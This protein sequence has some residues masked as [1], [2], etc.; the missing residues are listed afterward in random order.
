[1]A[2]DMNYAGGGPGA[3]K[4]N[5]DKLGGSGAVFTAAYGDHPICAPSRA[6]IM[7]GI[8]GGVS[9][10]YMGR[11][12]NYESALSDSYYWWDNAI[13]AN[14][15]Q[16]PEF[17]RSKCYYVAASGKVN[18]NE[19]PEA[20]CPECLWDEFY[21]EPDYGPYAFD[22]EKET[23]HDELPAA[24]AEISNAIDYGWARLSHVPYANTAKGG[25]KYAGG[26][27]K[28]GPRGMF[29]FNSVEDRAPTS[30][31]YNAE[32]AIQKIQQW[33]TTKAE[34]PWL[35]M[36][37]FVKPHTP[38]HCPDEHFDSFPLDEVVLPVGWDDDASDTFYEAASTEN[39][40]GYHLAHALKDSYDGGFEEGLRYW[41]QAYYACV[42]FVDVQVGKVVDA[43]EKSSFASN[44][45][46]VFMSDNG[47]QN[48]AKHY[49][50]K[51]SPW[52]EASKVPLIIKAPGVTNPGTVID[53]PVQ[54][55][56][57]YPTLMD[58]CGYKGENTIKAPPGHA[59][60]GTSVKPLLTGGSWGRD[61]VYSQVYPTANK[62][63]LPWP[64]CNG[65]QEC[66][67]WAMRYDDEAGNK[68]RYILYNNGDEELYNQKDDPD[69]QRNIAKDDASKTAAMKQKL[70]DGL[71]LDAAKAGFYDHKETRKCQTW[72]AKNKRT[73]SQKCV[74]SFGDCNSCPQ[75]AWL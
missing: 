50:Y 61:A 41:M 26:K 58:L 68:W 72:C 70:I 31:E 1:M 53:T 37:G 12:G 19:L 30:D 10:Y 51:N 38:L 75:C 33:E 60:T 35:L 22:G 66:N 45:I 63:V 7:S 3:K 11:W 36:V 32:W 34:D 24:L 55:T 74:P 44:T 56:D 73:W 43:L 67:H 40:N 20:G 4:P 17:F 47:W 29:K 52:S 48:G 8:R 21:A 46:I 16:I 25:W 57:V 5:L 69:E 2:D 62:I 64:D 42:E 65:I 15:M 71:G 39:N 54:L 49:V 23:H 14:S 6:S 18:H 28:G 27:N 59:L 13:L 9:G